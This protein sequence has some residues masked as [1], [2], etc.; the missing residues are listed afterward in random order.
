MQ[1]LKNQ[2]NM[3]ISYLEVLS[4]NKNSVKTYYFIIKK[5][6]TSL[7]TFYYID[8]KCSNRQITELLKNYE[9]ITTCYYCI[10]ILDSFDDPSP[11]R[12]I[13]CFVFC[14]MSMMP[15][16]RKRGILS[17]E[18]LRE[19]VQRLKPWQ[20]YIYIKGVDEFDRNCNKTLITCDAI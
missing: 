10:N 5:P 1:I 16:S 3:F 8:I 20:S 6:I 17:K 15:S 11:L 14:T 18:G 9:I 12:N 13:C 4:N 19:D 7:L 2:N